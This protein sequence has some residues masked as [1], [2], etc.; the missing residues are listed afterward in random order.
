MVVMRAAA[1]VGASA[2]HRGGAEASPDGVELQ[3]L[4]KS[5]AAPSGTTAA[6]QGGL[7][8]SA[9]DGALATGGR[10][11]LYDWMRSAGFQ[12][13]SMICTL[14][15]ALL[16][17]DLCNGFIPPSLDVA[18]LSVGL[19]VVFFFFILEMVAAVAARP[20]YACEL[21]FALDVVATLSLMTD[22]LWMKEA[23]DVSE[24]LTLARSAR[25]ARVGARV[26]L[27]VG[28]KVI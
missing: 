1:A 10:R 16:V 28:V 14:F 25:L 11:K 17:P 19:S 6:L 21:Y 23:I 22:I 15:Y 13:L 26:G 27:A 18:L 20:A 4:S 8:G 3:P 7:S 24:E 2:Q 12:S 9:P 5:T